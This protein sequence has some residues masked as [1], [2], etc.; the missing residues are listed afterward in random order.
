MQVQIP[1]RRQWW[2]EI[3]FLLDFFVVGVISWTISAQHFMIQVGLGQRGWLSMRCLITGVRHMWL[4]GC[5]TSLQLSKLI[6]IE[7]IIRRWNS[8]TW[9][10]ESRNICWNQGRCLCVSIWPFPW[11]ELWYSGN[12]W[13]F[14]FDFS[15]VASMI[16]PVGKTL[17]S[18]ILQ[19]EKYLICLP[20]TLI[21]KPHRVQHRLVLLFY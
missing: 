4:G 15:L 16:P 19:A 14:K 3:T 8:H 20:V 2:C 9:V 21:L 13:V 17:S 10:G 1:S 11:A 12:T 7:E 6:F 5:S 18:Q